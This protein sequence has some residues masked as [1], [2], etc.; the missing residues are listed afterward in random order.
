M[1]FSVFGNLWLL[2]LFYTLHFFI[3]L[4]IWRHMY[5][6]LILKFMPVYLRLLCFNQ[7]LR[8]NMIDFHE[9]W[10]IADERHLLLSGV[11]LIDLKIAVYVINTYSNSW[12]I[13][14]FFPKVLL[15]LWDTNYLILDERLNLVYSQTIFWNGPSF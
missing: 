8:I 10:L 4:W 2:L 3:L 1:Q 11:I 14:F 5:R 13:Q 7:R 9:F 6:R 12:A 15:R